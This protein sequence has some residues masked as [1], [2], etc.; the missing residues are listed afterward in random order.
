MRLHI[1]K[2]LNYP[3]HLL[4]I[5]DSNVTGYNTFHVPGVNARVE[6]G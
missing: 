2:P 1:Q 6:R 5:P 3:T 4:R